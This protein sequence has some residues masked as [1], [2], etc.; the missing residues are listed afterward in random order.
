MR[1]RSPTQPPRSGPSNEARRTPPTWVQ[2]DQ[3]S[4][5]RMVRCQVKKEQRR[6]RKVPMGTWP[7]HPL[8]VPSCCPPARLLSVLSQAISIL[9]KNDLP[10]F[11]A[12]LSLAFL[13]HCPP[14]SACSYASVSSSSSYIYHHPRSDTP[15]RLAPYDLLYHDCSHRV[16]LSLVSSSLTVLSRTPSRTVTHCGHYPTR[17]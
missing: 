14:P 8:E 10:T 5:T 15:R 3:A 16:T 13:G 7:L 9:N 4:L 6:K 17:T 12:S 11:F 1:R 2:G